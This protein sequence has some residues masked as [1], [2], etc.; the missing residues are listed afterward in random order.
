[1]TP[2]Y[3]FGVR[4]T[5]FVLVNKYIFNVM[6]RICSA[7]HFGIFA[8]KMFEGVI[9]DISDSGDNPIQ[10]G[11]KQYYKVL[12]KGCYCCLVCAVKLPNKSNTLVTLC[13]KLCTACEFFSLEP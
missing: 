8:P 12:S 5:W 9:N 7:K 11:G 4:A 1:M 2:L 6:Q 13:I 3:N 10:A